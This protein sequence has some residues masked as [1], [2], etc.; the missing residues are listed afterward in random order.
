MALLGRRPDWPKLQGRSNA[1]LYL[2]ARAADAEFVAP[3][4]DHDFAV[5]R[6][7][8]RDCLFELRVERGSSQHPHRLVLRARHG[9]EESAWVL[10]G[11]GLVPPDLDPE[12]IHAGVEQRC[13][14][15]ANP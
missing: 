2:F 8:A 10:D 4:N 14:Y 9:G 15:F 11:P 5:V 12:Q 13:Y 7:T 3:A 6:G 1:A